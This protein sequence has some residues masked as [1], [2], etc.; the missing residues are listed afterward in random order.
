MVKKFKTEVNFATRVEQKLKILHLI[1]SMATLTVTRLNGA[2]KNRRGK[3][4]SKKLITL[5]AT[6]AILTSVGCVQKDTEAPVIT[7]N[8]KV[9]TAGT[10]VD[11][12]SLYSVKD[13][14]DDDPTVTIDGDLDTSVAGAYK[15]TVVAEDK[16]GNKS[17][18]IVKVVVKG[19]SSKKDSNTENTTSE[20]E[21]SP[22]S[23]SQSTSSASSSTSASSEANGTGNVVVEATVGTGASSYAPPVDT[24]ESDL[25]KETSTKTAD[26]EADVKA[27]IESAK[28]DPSQFLNSGSSLLNDG[29]SE[30]A[31]IAANGHSLSDSWTFVDNYFKNN[32]KDNDV[33]L[34][35]L[36]YYAEGTS[37][38][39][40]STGDADHFVGIV[41]SGTS[42]AP[43]S[44]S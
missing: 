15:L 16:A 7:V 35:E 20:D 42:D 2:S 5:L 41:V 29:F 40:R 26:S 12:K 27:F 39:W 38:G 18:E 14:M 33:D 25:E 3:N 43:S 28:S 6:T 21:D 1:T 11:K 30:H 13:N 22:V 34:Y 10:K 44:V 17:E 8:N 23:S 37:Y 31:V 32:P 9:V 19:E 4:V 36:Y 24:S